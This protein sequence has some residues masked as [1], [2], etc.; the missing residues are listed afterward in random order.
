MKIKCAPVLYIAVILAMS[1]GGCGPVTPYPLLNTFVPPEEGPFNITFSYPVEWEWTTSRYDWGL[2]YTTIYPERIT[3][4]IKTYVSD[5]PEIE[6]PQDIDFFLNN[7][8][9]V[10]QNKILEDRITQVDEHEAR[11]FLMQNT[12]EYLVGAD[13]WRIAVDV[14]FRSEDHVY[15]IGI[16]YVD[17]ESY[18]QFREK[19]NEIIAS[20]RFLP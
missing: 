10:P 12:K 14:F 5:S 20:I 15:R 16:T 9:A 3:I 2:I 19:F 8:I 13:D 1:I 18:S 11:W 4:F 6:M 7:R 17:T